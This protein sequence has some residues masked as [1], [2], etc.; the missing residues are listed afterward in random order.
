MDPVDRV[1]R[2]DM[3][4]PIFD[5]E[6]EILVR[7][8]SEQDL[9]TIV[10]ITNQAIR[11]TTAVW[12]YTPATIDSRRQ[13]LLDRQQRDYPVLAAEV[14]NKVVGFASFGDFR[15]WEGYRY[16]VEHSVYVTPDWQR[17]GI[18]RLLLSN[19]ID[20]ARAAGK[21]SMIAGIDAANSASILLHR[22]FGFVEVG[23]LPEVGWKFERWLDLVLL[24]LVLK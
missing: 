15:P 5:M 7:D 1:D 20:R 8:A 10:E 22:Q 24:Q 19:L 17:R 16:T 9:P 12:S 3:F 23:R 21:H 18:G 4:P 11:E 14:D 2:S 13:W 6:T